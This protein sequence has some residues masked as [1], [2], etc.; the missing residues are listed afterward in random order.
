MWNSSSITIHCLQSENDLQAKLQIKQRELLE[1]RKRKLELELAATH[2]QLE[3]TP[4]SM[5]SKPS[6]SNQMPDALTKPPHSMMPAMNPTPKNHINQIGHGVPTTAVSIAS[7]P[8]SNAMVIFNNFHVSQDH[9]V[10]NQVPIVSSNVRQRLA[11]VDSVLLANNVRASRDPRLLR[12]TQNSAQLPHG[13]AAQLP[14]QQQASLTNFN[15]PTQRLGGNF[16]NS[17]AIHRN[18]IARYP[19]SEFNDKSVMIANSSVDLHSKGTSKEA[20]HRT[21]SSASYKNSSKTSSKSPSSSGS[22]SKSK[23]SSKGTSSK[24]SRDSSRSGSGRARSSSSSSKDR[25]DDNKS[26]RKFP[27]QFSQHT[28]IE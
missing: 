15:G 24:S 12:Q 13:N 5:D 25:K 22:S 9:T 19:Q 23:S 8:I 11:P 3:L 4:V 21:S 1:L 7:I 20:K 18:R 2:K 14:A 10:M 16:P 28:Q 17:N 27:Q 6:I 26:P